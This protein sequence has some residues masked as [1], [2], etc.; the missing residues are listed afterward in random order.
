M[1]PGLPSGAEPPPD[2]GE[3]DDDDYRGFP[4][5]C[6]DKLKDAMKR[7][8][9]DFTYILPIIENLDDIIKLYREISANCSDKIPFDEFRNRQ[10]GR[11]Y[12]LDSFYKYLLEWIERNVLD[13]FGQVPNLKPNFIPLSNASL[14]Y[15]NDG[16]LFTQ[17]MDH[18]VYNGRP[19]RFT[20]GADKYKSWLNQSEET[21][22]FF[23]PI[24]DFSAIF[25]GDEWDDIDAWIYFLSQ[26]A[27]TFR[28]GY[29]NTIPLS[30]Y[31]D[32]VNHLQ[33]YAAIPV[34]SMI[35]DVLK[36]ELN[37]WSGEKLT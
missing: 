32:F 14:N 27:Y 33:I 18:A 23:P 35:P 5:E 21:R 19:D 10:I 17:W 7:L 8:M 12:D 29:G 4:P 11:F 22:S 9:D 3:F 1:P 37:D 2:P 36:E 15:P 25:D 28:P 30:D 13:T 31:Q 6:K 20:V 16:G 34:K 26:L 24:K